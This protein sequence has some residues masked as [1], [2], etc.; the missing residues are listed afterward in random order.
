M[1]ELPSYLHWQIKNGSQ[2]WLWNLGSQIKQLTDL[3]SK[4][5]Y[6][7]IKY[8][9]ISKKKVENIHHDAV[10]YFFQDSIFWE[11][12]SAKLIIDKTVWSKC[13]TITKTRWMINDSI[14]YLVIRLIWTN[15][16]GTR[17]ICQAFSLFIIKGV[18]TWK[19]CVLL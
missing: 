18:Q 8:A 6:Q 14:W 3:I 12:L 1:K 5:H 4:M 9:Q 19:S 13:K 15:K 16:R 11:I 7:N 17:E 2:I 10:T